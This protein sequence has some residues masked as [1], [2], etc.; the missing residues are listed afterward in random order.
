MSIKQNAEAYISMN[1]ENMANAH[2]I[3]SDE[4]PVDNSGDRRATPTNIGQLISTKLGDIRNDEGNLTVPFEILVEADLKF[5][6]GS[7]QS[8]IKIE[9]SG[10]LWG[11]EK[12]FREYNDDPDY[13]DENPNAFLYK[14]GQLSTGLG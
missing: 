5:D 11:V 14:A 1:Y 13:V 6:D 9:V 2:Y 12:P 7:E 10:E 3:Y 8:G 4:F